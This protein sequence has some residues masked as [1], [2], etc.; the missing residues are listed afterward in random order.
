MIKDAD[1]YIADLNRWR[2]ERKVREDER[3]L[4]KQKEQ[5]E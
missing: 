1:T 5:D 4:K 3:K 2:D